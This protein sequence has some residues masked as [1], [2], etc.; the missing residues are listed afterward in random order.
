MR[1]KKT[2][3]KTAKTKTKKVAPKAPTIMDRLPK[4][5]GEWLELV[6]KMTEKHII[7]GRPDYLVSQAERLKAE[8]KV[9]KE[10][11]S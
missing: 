10:E 8:L 1:T 6:I 11:N 7:D 4:N 3:A 5:R 2:K 9:W